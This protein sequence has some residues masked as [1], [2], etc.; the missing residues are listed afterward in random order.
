MPQHLPPGN[1]AQRQ[2]RLRHR[3]AMCSAGD[4][5]NDRGAADVPPADE[6]PADADDARRADGLPVG[7][8]GARREVVGRD[9]ACSARSSRSD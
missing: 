1:R 6:Q 3:D 9:R 7:E 5:P 8:G 4:E 2:P